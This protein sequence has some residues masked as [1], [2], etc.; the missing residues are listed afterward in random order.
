MVELT[1]IVAMQY[2]YDGPKSSFLVS[3]VV[4]WL[5]D[6]GLLAPMFNDQSI[7]FNPFS[8][9]CHYKMRYLVYSFYE[10][11]HANLKHLES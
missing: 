6:L 11:R 8:S 9:V 2:E 7:L 1:D 10:E 4:Q 5:E 3:T